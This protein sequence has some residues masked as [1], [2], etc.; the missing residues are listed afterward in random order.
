MG[1]RYRWSDDF[2]TVMAPAIS[3]SLSTRAD[4]YSFNYNEPNYNCRDDPILL[5]RP[6]ADTGSYFTTSHV[7]MRQTQTEQKKSIIIS[8]VHFPLD[9]WS[10]LDRTPSHPYLC[11]EISSPRIGFQLRIIEGCLAR[12]SSLGIRR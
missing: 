12:C 9:R 6:D 10:S 11:F 3:G 7:A 1:R 2:A 8:S 5:R 4:D